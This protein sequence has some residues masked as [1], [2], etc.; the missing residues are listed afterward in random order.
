MIL[1]LDTSSLVKLYVSEDHAD[2]VV[3]E[4]AEASVVA[5]SVIA[6]PEARSAFSLQHRNSVLTDAEHD[7]IKASLA[8]SWPRFL[9]IE[10][11]EEIWRQAGDLADTFALRTYDSLHLAS[12]L[13]LAARTS[14][15]PVRFS[16]FD[17]QLNRA[18]VAATGLTSTLAH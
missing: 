15:R 3:A 11:C 10:V 13:F 8:S 6:Y 9:S 7:R 17:P 1:Y 5:T 16:C 18:A 2:A 4:A 14:G 12:Y